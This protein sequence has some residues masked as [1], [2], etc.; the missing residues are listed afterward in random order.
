M[1]MMTSMP[2]N[3]PPTHGFGLGAAIFSTNTTNAKRIAIEEIEARCIAINYFTRIDPY[4]PFG[5]IK[6]CGYGRELGKIGSHN[7]I[8]SKSI[9][10]D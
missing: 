7:F 8:N 1:Q 2:L 6:D 10:G 9:V 4:V 5:G 3:L